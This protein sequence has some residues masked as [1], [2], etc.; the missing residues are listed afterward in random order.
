MIISSR[1]IIPAAIVGFASL[2]G[3]AGPAR[4]TEST[5]SCQVASFTFNDNTGGQDNGGK[6]LYIQ[7]TDNLN[8]FYQ[9]FIS[10]PI[11]NGC[12]LYSVDTVKAWQSQAELALSSGRTLTIF[13]FSNSGCGGVKQIASITSN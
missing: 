5:E 3:T 12:T 8:N 9:A 11:V 6:Q 10:Q 13:W 2:I 4:A 7:C 1:K